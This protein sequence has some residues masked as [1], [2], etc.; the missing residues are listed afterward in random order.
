MRFWLLL[1]V[2]LLWGDV[3]AQA[4]TRDFH[5]PDGR[6]IA[7]VTSLPPNAD[8]DNGEG[9]V[10]VSRSGKRPCIRRSFAS[11]DGEHGEV[12]E[13]VAWTPDS[14][15][16]VLTT[17]SSGGHSAWHHWTFVW[18][19]RDNKIHSFDDACQCTVTASFQVRWPDILS[20]RMLDVHAPEDKD[21]TSPGVPIVVR[22][23]RVRWKP[24]IGM[25]R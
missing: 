13:R 12:I 20:T 8:G 7:S 18:S 16:F 1:A 2:G 19:R 5:S 4:G 6:Y 17:F 11:G 3:P 9:I 14:Y 25:D 23:S 10:T 15:F 24:G 21:A 22:L